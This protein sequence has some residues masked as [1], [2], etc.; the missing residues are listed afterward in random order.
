MFVV[1]GGRRGRRTGG[2]VVVV[3]TFVTGGRVVVVPVEAGGR[4]L[5]GF[6]ELVPGGREPGGRV[7]LVGWVVDG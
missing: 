5:F 4:L 6:V 7:G 1:A 2:R 3:G